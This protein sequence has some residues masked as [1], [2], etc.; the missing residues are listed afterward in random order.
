MVKKTKNVPQSNKNAK[1][2]GIL[3]IIE[4]LRTSSIFGK[5][6]VFGNFA[7]KKLGFFSKEKNIT[8]R[9]K[10]H[11]ETIVTSYM[12]IKLLFVYRSVPFYS[13]RFVFISSSIVTIFC[14]EFLYDL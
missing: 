7:K 8:Y 6:R 4:I 11:A 2:N 9:D 3:V 10:E 12:F 14:S 13:C 5:K 1:Q